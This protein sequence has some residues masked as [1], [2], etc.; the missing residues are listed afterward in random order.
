MEKIPARLFLLF[1]ALLVPVLSHQPSLKPPFELFPYQDKLFHMVEFGG[2]ALAMVLNRDL[3]RRIGGPWGM[4]V[5]GL[6][7]AVLDEVHQSYVP[8][9]DSSLQDLAADAVGLAAG[10][11]LFRVL[12]AG[13]RKDS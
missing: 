6:L 2:L 3:F 12:L 1:V 5:S 8:G 9:R 13:R 7:W 10:I 11:L 4:A